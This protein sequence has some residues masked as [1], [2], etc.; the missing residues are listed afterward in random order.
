M[1]GVPV[2]MAEEVNTV[3]ASSRDH[4]KITTNL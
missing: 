4:I 1:N 3:L 2:K